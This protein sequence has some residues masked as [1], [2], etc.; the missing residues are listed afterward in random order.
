M[1]W[2]T[3]TSVITLVIGTVFTILL[4]VK[5]PDKNVRVVALLWQFVLFMQLFE[6]LSWISKNTQNNTLSKF[7]TLGAFIFNVLQPIVAGLLCIL[8]SESTTIKYTLSILMILYIMILFY[9]VSDTSFENPLYNNE[10]TC[11]HLQLYWWSGFSILVFILYISII[12]ISCLSL[13]PLR[14]GIFQLSYI[15]I[16]LLLS[17]WLYPCTYGSIWCW[18]AAFA[19]ILTFL[20]LFFYPI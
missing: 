12:S 6:A 5:Y 20:Y 4:L 10:E 3:E 2:N 1:C 18:F 8:I 19:P 16:T 9:Y 13:L 14:F 7:S 15:I 11:H 17:I